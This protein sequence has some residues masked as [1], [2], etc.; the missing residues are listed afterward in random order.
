MKHLQHTYETS[1]TLKTYAYN[2]RFSPFFFCATQS[3][4]GNSRR[5]RMETRLGGGQL[6][7]RL[8]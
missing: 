8:A 3:R 2:L 7:L 5:P 4:A 1:K 6:R